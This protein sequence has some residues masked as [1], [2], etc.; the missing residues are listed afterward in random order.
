MSDPTQLLA[1]LNALREMGLVSDE[2]YQLRK[3]QVLEAHS[4]NSTGEPTLSGA[5]TIDPAA[6]RATLPDRLSS[7]STTLDPHLPTRVGKYDLLEV[8]G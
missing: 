2:E 1:D 7:G 4:D 6:S 5:T 3:Q 8:V